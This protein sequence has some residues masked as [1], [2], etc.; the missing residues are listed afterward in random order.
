MADSTSC[1]V[2]LVSRPPSISTASASVGEAD[3]GRQRGGQRD[4][5]SGVVVDPCQG[6]DQ[7]HGRDASTSLPTARRGHGPRRVATS[8]R[9]RR[10]PSSSQRPIGTSPATAPMS[11]RLERHVPDQVLDLGDLP[12]GWAAMNA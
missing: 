8:S 5:V 3:T 11:G 9:R 2:L 4:Q 6:A 7:P 1:R 10:G 12:S